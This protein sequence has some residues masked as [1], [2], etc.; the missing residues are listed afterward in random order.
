MPDAL[1]L[2]AAS[3]RTIHG[4]QGYAA[5]QLGR[6][7]EPTGGWRIERDGDPICEA[8]SEVDARIML[9][10]LA[11]VPATEWASARDEALRDMGH[12]RAA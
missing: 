4:A 7:G 3:F 12:R 8:A 1:T 11:G 5:H 2:G 6:F 9:N 10:V